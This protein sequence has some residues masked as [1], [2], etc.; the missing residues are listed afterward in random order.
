M[1]EFTPFVIACLTAMTVAHG[2]KCSKDPEG[3]T[4]SDVNFQS[5]GKV[6]FGDAAYLKIDKWNNED[7]M[8]I[9]DF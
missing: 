3:C 4:V 7:F 6:D 1:I 5:I 8:L 2:N 9:T